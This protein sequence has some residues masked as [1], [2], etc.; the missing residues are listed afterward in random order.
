[1]RL[2]ESLPGC[3]L[4]RYYFFTRSFFI[5][6]CHLVAPSF[7]GQLRSPEP[8]GRTLSPVTMQSAQTAQLFGSLCLF[9]D[10]N[11]S[12][13]AR[14]RAS[15]G[16]RPLPPY[17]QATAMPNASITTDVH[18]SLDVHRDFSPQATFNLVIGQCGS[19]PSNLIICQIFYA[20]VWI[21]LGLVQYFPG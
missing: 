17:R 10:A 19:N 9:A 11:G 7:Y 12:T 20:T 1:M 5:T 2:A 4:A 14:S 21:H 18:K 15:I 16:M 8:M 6:T 13:S 3:W